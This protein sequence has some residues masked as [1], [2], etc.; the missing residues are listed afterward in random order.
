[1]P[2]GESFNDDFHKFTL[3]WDKDGLTYSLDGQ[4][5]L[6]VPTDEGYWK[7]GQF[8]QKLPDDNNVW[9]HDSLDAPFNQEFYIIMNVAVGGTGG[10]FP[11]S[12]TNDGYP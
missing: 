6:H 8:D 2:N 11:D 1:M 3:D 4:K 10:F 7:K 5:I 12:L 9:R